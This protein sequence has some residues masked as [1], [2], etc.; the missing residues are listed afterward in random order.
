MPS[1]F[2]HVIAS[3]FF[4]R[5][6]AFTSR[7]KVLLFWAGFCAFAPD[8][9]VIG[10]H[11][12]VPYQSEWGHRGFTHSICFGLVFGLVI[13]WLVGR[14]AADFKKIAVLMVLSTISHPLLDMLTNGGRGC[15]LWWPFR[16]DR[17][18]FP[19]RPIQVSPLGI[20]DF[21][22]GWGAEALF[23]ELLW[24]GIPCLMLYIGL[25]AIRMY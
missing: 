17:I 19:F 7:Q 14:N 12:G 25:R 16:Q 6:L 3:T 18:F 4:T 8:L 24:V 20:A 9:D 1:I 23:S 21:F 10:F 15:A 2:G 13:A 5:V 11:F 22:T